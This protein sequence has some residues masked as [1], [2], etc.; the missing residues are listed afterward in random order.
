MGDCIDR[1]S[2]VESSKYFTTYVPWT[3]GLLSPYFGYVYRYDIFM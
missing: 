2:T 1:E 3:V